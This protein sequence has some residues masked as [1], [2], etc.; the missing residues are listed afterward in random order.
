MRVLLTDR[1]CDRAK[2][3][4]QTDYF[5]ENVSGLALRV[6]KHGV[7]SWTLI[8][9]A[10]NGK[11]ARMTL[12]RYPMMSLAGARARA[13]EARGAVA[14][15]RDP[16][17]PTANTLSAVVDEYFRREGPKLRRTAERR[18]MFDRG[19]LPILGDRP[20][21]D[22]RRSEIVRLLDDINDN[23][24]PRAAGLTFTYLSKVFNWHASRDDEFRSPMVRGM[25][26][27]K[28]PARDR[29]LSDEEIRAVWATADRAGVFGLYVRF[30]L[31]TATRRNEAARMV[32][33]EVVDGVWSIPVERMKAKSE[34]VVPLSTLALATL[35]QCPSGA[36]VFTTDGTK[37]IG[38]FGRL[39]AEFDALVPLPNWTLHDLRRTA[40]SL[41]SR[42]GVSADIA[43][44]CLAHT[45]GGV[46]GV[47]D[48]HAY[49]EE[50]R[51]AFEALA[52]LIDR[53]VNPRENVVEL[54]HG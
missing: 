32:R 6:T 7:K 13:L 29:V 43:E 11:R 40:R 54:G 36:L 2:S 39:K 47:Y 53:I 42:A 19:V 15:G 49:L 33:S 14:E 30:L 3:T 28:S 35:E 20:I 44:R 52:S 4:G 12:G 51:K 17:P 22:I 38:S 27:P 31:L 23:R 41:M 21:A 26:P 10:P 9:T 16:Q 24:G 5:D 37:P 1:F 18:S 8:Y 48:R 34:H 46:R 25:A 50:K 45:I